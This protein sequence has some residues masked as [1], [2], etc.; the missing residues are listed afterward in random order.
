MSSSRSLVDF[1]RCFQS[2]LIAR[3]WPSLVRVLETS[4][5]LQRYRNTVKKIPWTIIQE[6]EHQEYTHTSLS[7]RQSTGGRHD[8]KPVRRIPL[9][10]GREAWNICQ[11][12]SADV[13]RRVVQIWRILLRRVQH[14]LLQGWSVYKTMRRSTM[15]SDDR[16]HIA[17]SWVDDAW[18][19]KQVT[20]LHTADKGHVIWTTNGIAE[21]TQG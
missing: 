10:K 3:V 17:V 1:F 6:S 9:R 18:L 12:Q 16:K 15:K 8:N 21:T 11:K 20:S 7:Q 4:R 14:L 5:G 19:L 13:T 2:L